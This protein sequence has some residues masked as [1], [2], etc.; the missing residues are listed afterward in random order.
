MEPRVGFTDLG[1]VAWADSLRR[2]A[3]DLGLHSEASS[4]GTPGRHD[5]REGLGSGYGGMGGKGEEAVSK[6]RGQGSTRW[7]SL[8]GQWLKGI[9]LEGG[10]GW[11][12]EQHGQKVWGMYGGF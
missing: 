2:Q 6:E 12:S 9:K 10:W 7:Q 5:G 3:L 8:K 1:L 11:V 4:T